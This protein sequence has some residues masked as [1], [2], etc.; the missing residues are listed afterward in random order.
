LEVANLN[1]PPP[2]KMF[3]EEQNYNH[4]IDFNYILDTGNNLFLPF[5][6]QK[7]ESSV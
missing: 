2:V 3:L 6:R 1:R 7:Q 5:R 4:N